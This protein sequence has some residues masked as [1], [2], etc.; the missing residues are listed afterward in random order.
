M[1]REKILTMTVGGSLLA[2][3]RDPQSP[4]L[5]VGRILHVCVP[6]ILL[7][8]PGIPVTRLKRQTDTSKKKESRKEE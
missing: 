7:C 6:I 3:S 5:N 8:S 1:A 2:S 4:L